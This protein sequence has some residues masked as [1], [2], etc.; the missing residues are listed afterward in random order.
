MRTFGS[1]LLVTSRVILVTAA[2]RIGS[3][4]R[5]PQVRQGT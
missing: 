1:T 5:N 2:G 4:K 3:K